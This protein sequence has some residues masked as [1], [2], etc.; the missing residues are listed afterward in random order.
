MSVS[1]PETIRSRTNDAQRAAHQRVD[2]AAV[3]A[4]AHVAADRAQRRDPLED[5]LPAR[6][7]RACAS[8]CRRWRGTRGSR[9]WHCFSASIRLTVRITSSRL[10]G[11]QVAAAGAAVDEQADRRSRGGARSPR[12]PAAPST[13]SSCRS[14][15]RPSGRRG[16]PRSSRAGSPPGWRPS[17]RRDRSPTRP[18]GACPRP[19]SAPW[20][21]RCRRASRGAAPAARARRSRGRRSPGR[22]CSR[23]I[24]LPARDPLR[25]AQRVASSSSSRATTASTTLDRGDHERGEQRPAEAVDREH[26]VGHVG[27]ERAGSRVGDQHEQEAEHERGRQPQRREHAAGRPRSAPR[28]PPRRAARPRSSS[29]L[30]PGRSPAATISATPIASHETASAHSRKRGRSGCHAVLALD[31]GADMAED[32][33]AIAGIPRRP[34]GRR[35]LASE[36]PRWNRPP[37][38]SRPLGALHFT[39]RGA[40]SLLLGDLAP[41]HRRRTGRRGACRPSSRRRARPAGARG[42][43]S[44]RW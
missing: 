14:P 20:S 2:A 38:C 30:T 11:E 15:S 16:C 22:R 13:S 31:V 26:P 10:A 43:R 40:L 17:A 42:G 19:S 5:D 41:S 44:R 21:G 34:R 3:P 33:L 4:R 8:R 27:G 18:G 39:L 9:G 7:A 32:A 29:M 24:A 37:P 6:R 35:R 23:S 1:T 12:S 36:C 25:D 28:R